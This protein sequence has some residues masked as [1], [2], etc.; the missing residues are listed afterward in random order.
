MTAAE[1][2]LVRDALTK[3]RISI[4]FMLRPGEHLLKEEAEAIEA[5]DKAMAVLDPPKEWI[6]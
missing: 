5:I 2:A 6:L 3:A 1:L 4:T